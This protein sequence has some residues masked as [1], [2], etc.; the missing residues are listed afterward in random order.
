MCDCKNCNKCI[1]KFSTKCAGVFLVLTAILEILI[2]A[3]LALLFWNKSPD[4]T[5]YTS[6]LMFIVSA[7]VL[8]CITVIQISC[9]EFYLKNLKLQI[10]CKNQDIIKE[11]NTIS[12]SNKTKKPCCSSIETETSKEISENNVKPWLNAVVDV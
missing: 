4:I 9:F 10:L 8:I 12:S 5:F 6:V 11:K 3:G 7:L 2:C 1:I